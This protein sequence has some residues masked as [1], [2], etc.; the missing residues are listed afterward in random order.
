MEDA[1]ICLLIV[2]GIG[3]Q[4]RDIDHLC[5]DAGFHTAGNVYVESEYAI[6]RKLVSRG[7]S[8]ERVRA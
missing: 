8:R 7:L 6:I 1:A 3:I 2:N 4:P 5:V